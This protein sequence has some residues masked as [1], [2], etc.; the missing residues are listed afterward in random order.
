MFGQ[1]VAF[2]DVDSDGDLDAYVLSWGTPPLTWPGQDNRLYRNQGNGAC[3]LGRLRVEA[4]G[5]AGP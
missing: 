5:A 2:G 3:G 4:M 1:G